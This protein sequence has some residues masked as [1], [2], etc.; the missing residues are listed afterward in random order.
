MHICAKHQKNDS[1]SDCR[2]VALGIKKPAS[3]DAG[4]GEAGQAPTQGVAQ[5]HS[6]QT[7]PFGGSVQRNTTVRGV[8]MMYA[9][10]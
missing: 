8:L 10:P 5:N 3:G 4:E 9:R 6:H 1:E 2:F 7:T